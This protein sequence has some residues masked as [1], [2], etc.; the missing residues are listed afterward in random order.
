MYVRWRR[1]LGSIDPEG[2]AMTTKN[3]IS[4]KEFDILRQRKWIQKMMIVA[5]RMAFL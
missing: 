2:S 4:V 3:L 1:K 5:K